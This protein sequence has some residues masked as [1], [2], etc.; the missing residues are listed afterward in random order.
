MARVSA[1][2]LGK[3][4]NKNAHEVNLLLEKKGFIKKSKYVT[5]SG[6][7]LWD[8]TE[9]G[10]L[11]GENSRHPYSSGYIWDKEVAEILKKLL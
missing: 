1:R 7:P 9:L 10:R 2:L 8:I 4:I 6:S 5:M 3:I 11:H